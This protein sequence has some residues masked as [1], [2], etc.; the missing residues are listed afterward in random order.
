MNIKYLGPIYSLE[1][2]SRFQDIDAGCGTCGKRLAEVVHDPSGQWNVEDVVCLDC[3]TI[4]NLR[5]FELKAST[6]VPGRRVAVC[7]LCPYVSMPTDGDK[8]A[9]IALAHLAAA[10]G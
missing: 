3:G 4:A 10:H 9:E 1:D 5:P 8:A 7:M 6:K 2:G